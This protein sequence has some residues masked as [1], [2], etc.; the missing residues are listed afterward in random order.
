M[1]GG[2]GNLR[3]SQNLKHLS[4]S[5]VHFYGFIETEREESESEST[6]VSGLHKQ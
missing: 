3:H 6:Q 1:Y 4:V 5:R 2:E